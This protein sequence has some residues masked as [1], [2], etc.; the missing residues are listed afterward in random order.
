MS[1]KEVDGQ[2]VVLAFLLIVYLLLTI[3]QIRFD[4]QIQVLYGLTFIILV[5]T[6]F[7][8]LLNI[9]INHKGPYSI[10]LYNLIGMLFNVTFILSLF[11]GIYFAI[12]PDS[13]TLASN[14]HTISIVIKWG[15]ILMSSLFALK[16]IFI[17]MPLE[18]TI[19]GSKKSKFHYIS[20][21]YLYLTP[22][23]FIFAFV[24][25][26]YYKYD[27]SSNT[28]I[29]ATLFIFPLLLF[30]FGTYIDLVSLFNQKYII[31]LR[32]LVHCLDWY[33][34]YIL[35]ILTITH[36]IQN[37]NINQSMGAP[38]LLT[39]PFIFLMYNVREYTLALGIQKLR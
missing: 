3:I 30:V 17:Y 11:I 2:K 34:L 39:V 16:K 37:T 23:I 26:T 18:N 7:Y 12:R 27:L 8:G 14:T 5:G 36:L 21:K 6:F 9:I 22:L 1:R 20:S 29:L 15:V 38:L 32:M 10:L 24:F 25:N 33:V 13:F 31:I 4:V 19:F 28:K 35:C